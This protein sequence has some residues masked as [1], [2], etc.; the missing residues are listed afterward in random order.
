MP[1]S[2]IGCAKQGLA[3]LEA[4]NKLVHGGLGPMREAPIE[5]RGS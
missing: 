4:R 5:A 2:R 1:S 3:K